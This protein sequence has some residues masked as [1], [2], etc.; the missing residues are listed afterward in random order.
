[1]RGWLGVMN[2]SL[3]KINTIVRSDVQ[4]FLLSLLHLHFLVVASTLSLIL[5]PE[6]LR[7]E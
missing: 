1:M 6:S 2:H 5:K 3:D 7:H 4:L